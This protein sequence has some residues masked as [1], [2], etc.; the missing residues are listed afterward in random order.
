MG[1]L[2]PWC[3]KN[4]DDSQSNNNLG[5]GSVITTSQ[6]SLASSEVND[7]TPFVIYLFIKIK[8]DLL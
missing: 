1:N 3:C 4:S 5:D 7:R 8:Y 2:C 6:R